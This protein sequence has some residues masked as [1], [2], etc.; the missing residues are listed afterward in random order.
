MTELDEISFSQAPS[1]GSETLVLRGDRVIIRYAEAGELVER[2]V[3]IEDIAPNIEF[4]D[5]RFTRF[6]LPS[7]IFAVVLGCAAW[8]VD[9]SVPIP[10]SGTISGSDWASLALVILFASLALASVAV[11]VVMCDSIEVA[12][13]R[14]KSGEPLF[15]LFR[16]QSVSLPYAEFLLALKRRLA[17]QQ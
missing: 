6:L 2:H 10:A 3:R 5:R 14:S 9:R 11:G 1:L 17:T 12:K 15:Q 16:H 4:T 13:V 7:L 8:K